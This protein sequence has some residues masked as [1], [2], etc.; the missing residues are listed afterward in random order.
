MGD[1]CEIETMELRELA[2]IWCNE[3][4]KFK[5]QGKEATKLN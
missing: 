1:W 3:L 2:E 5:A 4:K